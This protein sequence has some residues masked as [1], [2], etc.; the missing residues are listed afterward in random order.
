[1]KGGW[2]GPVIDTLRNLY[3][4]ISFRLKRNCCVSSKIFSNLGINQGGV[5]SGLLFRKY[6]ADLDS[7]LSLEY[8]VCIGDE[9]VAHLLW[10][11]DLILFSDTFH[12]LQKQ[13]HR[14]KQFCYN[15]H[16][17]VNEMNTKV[18]VFGNPKR[19]KIFFNQKCIEEVKNCKYLGNIISSTRLP[20][21]DPLKSTYKFL[22]DQAMKAVFNMRRKIKSIGELP[23]NIMLNLFDALIKPILIYGSE[24]WG[25]AC[26]I[27]VLWFTNR[28][29]HMSNDALVKKVYCV[30]MELNDQGFTTW[31][32]NA[33]ELVNDLGLDLNDVQKK[34]AIN[35]KHAVQS[36]YIAFWFANLHDI[37]SNPILRTY[38]TMKYEY[39]MEPYLYHVKKSQYRYSI[40]NYDAVHTYWK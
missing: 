4:N 38:R 28:L 7:Y 19:S 15:N 23:P 2:H 40:A 1:M 34:F 9:I 18:M 10:A 20:N 39:S 30:I 17:I 33:L 3:D 14:L 35:F 24:F 21:Q 25:T 13:L 16:M 6:I 12:G 8:G 37:Q 36:N 27:S 22:S 26:Q 32:T 5:A 11:D 29:H 31:A